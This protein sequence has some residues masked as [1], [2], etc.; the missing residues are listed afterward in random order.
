MRVVATIDVPAP[1]EA[2]WAWVSDPSRYLEFMVGATRWDVESAQPIGLGARYRMLMRVGAVELGGLIEVVEFVAPADLAWTS[3]TGVEQ[4]GRWR[5]R[6]RDGGGT[7][8]ELR[9]TYGVP[10]FEPAAWLIGRI[11]ARTVRGNLRRS[12]RELRRAVVEDELGRRS[13]RA[14]AA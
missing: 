14:R 2:V 13:G 11:A 5:L 4:R 10:G 3:I 1:P 9:L 7:H 6:A 12:L 8:V